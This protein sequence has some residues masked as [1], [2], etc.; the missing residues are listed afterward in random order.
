MIGPLSL[1]KVHPKVR[2]KLKKS[3]LKFVHKPF[4]VNNEWLIIKLEEYFESKLDKHSI[5]K[6]KSEMLDKDIEKELLF[7]YADELKSIL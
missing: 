2:E 7:N 6:L 5:S 3:F 4:R 1:V